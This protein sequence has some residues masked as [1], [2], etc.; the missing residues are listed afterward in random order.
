MLDSLP[1]RNDAAIVLR[2]LMRSL[3]TRTGVLGVA[4]CDKGL[5]AM[6]MALVSSG[7][8]PSVLIPGGVTLLPENGEAKFTPGQ[9]SS[10]LEALEEHI[11]RDMILDGTR[12]D[13]RTPKQL[14][15]ISCEVGVPKATS[16]GPECCELSKNRQ[17]SANGRYREKKF[18]NPA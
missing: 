6:M 11:V 17:V 16:R 14:R 10:A 12:L 5:P 4:T 8:L 3:P 7:P 9:V 18:F 13:G 1:Y 15:Q 2:R